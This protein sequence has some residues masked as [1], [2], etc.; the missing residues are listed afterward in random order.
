MCVIKVTFDDIANIAR[1]FVSIK[2][3]A[4]IAI[5]LLEIVGS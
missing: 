1:W 3:I 4:K 5:N 2:V